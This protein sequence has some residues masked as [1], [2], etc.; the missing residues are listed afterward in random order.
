MV[1]YILVSIGFSAAVFKER[2]SKK[3][4]AGL[5]FIVAGTL[6]MLIK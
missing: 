5:F 4:A 1:Y 6:M 2:L 3:S